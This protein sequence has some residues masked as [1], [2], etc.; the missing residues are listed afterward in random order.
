MSCP[1][2]GSPVDGAAAKCDACGNPVPRTDVAP[3]QT[4]QR[5]YGTATNS[6]SC[7]GCGAQTVYSATQMT[8]ECPYCGSQKVIQLPPDQQSKT[9]Q[10]EYVIPFTVAKEQSAKRFREWVESLWFAP[11][12]LKQRAQSDAVRGVYLPFWVYDVKTCRS[13]K[14]F[15]LIGSA[16]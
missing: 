2:C 11:G 16:A 7:D 6:F 3:T 10:P 15:R 9:V 5:G 8:M 1:S 14:S 12:D 13:S 4:A